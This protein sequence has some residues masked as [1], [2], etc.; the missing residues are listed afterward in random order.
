MILSHCLGTLTGLIIAACAEDHQAAAR[1]GEPSLGDAITVIFEG[2]FYLTAFWK[3]TS[4]SMI[5]L[6]IKE[7]SIRAI[8]LMLQNSLA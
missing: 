6:L 3:V 8:L 2:F 4:P 1:S 5:P 7:C